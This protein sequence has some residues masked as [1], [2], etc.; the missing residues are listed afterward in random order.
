MRAGLPS[1]VQHTVA[2]ALPIGSVRP[3]AVVKDIGLLVLHTVGAN[4]AI[5]VAHG[6]LVQGIDEEGIDDVLLH[7]K[8]GGFLNLRPKCSKR[9]RGMRTLCVEVESDRREDILMGRDVREPVDGN[10]SLREIGDEPQD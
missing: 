9:S 1:L 8:P 7:E 10:L 3:A 4:P 6:P 2:A 5:R